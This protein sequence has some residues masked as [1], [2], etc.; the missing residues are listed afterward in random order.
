VTSSEESAGWI[1][2]ERDPLTS[3][4]KDPKRSETQKVATR[5]ERNRKPFISGSFVQTKN[6]EDVLARAR[7]EIDTKKASVLQRLELLLHRGSESRS[8]R[9]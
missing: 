6:P 7:R 2:R 9:R 5:Q 3:R 4:T 1:A 8:A